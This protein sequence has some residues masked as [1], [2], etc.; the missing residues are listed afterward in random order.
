MNVNV[1]DLLLFERRRRVLH[2][3][4]LRAYL[5]LAL[6]SVFTPDS[7]QG[8]IW[9]VRD[10]TRV[11]HMQAKHSTHCIISLDP[12]LWKYFKSFVWG[13]YTQHCSGLI[14]GFVF[15][16]HRV[17]NMLLGFKS[18]LHSRLAPNPKYGSLEKL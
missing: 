10:Q 1:R 14:P 7:A 6:S 3:A 8:I 11:G 12:K 16:N 15:R 4:V 2:P 17:L 5:F 13:N 18:V 9:G